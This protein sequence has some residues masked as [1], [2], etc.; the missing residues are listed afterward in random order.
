M[1]V[2]ESGAKSIEVGIMR[3]GVPM[4][5]ASE[6]RI[7]ALVAAIEKLGTDLSVDVR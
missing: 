1:E 5:M 4:E 3:R 2:V 6:A 7:E